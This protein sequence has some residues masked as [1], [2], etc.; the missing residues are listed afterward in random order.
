MPEDLTPAVADAWIRRAETEFGY[1]IT[2]GHL[3]FVLLLGGLVRCEASFDLMVASVKNLAERRIQL[4]H[5]LAEGEC[6]G[7]CRRI[8]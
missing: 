2:A 7:F 5:V 4:A 6:R 8:K 1:R 3:D